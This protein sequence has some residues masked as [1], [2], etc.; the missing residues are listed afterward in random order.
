LSFSFGKSREKRTLTGTDEVIIFGFQPKALGHEKI[1][2]FI[3]D[4]L[5]EP[6]NPAI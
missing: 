6:V 5:A 1:S 4:R 2:K 3:E